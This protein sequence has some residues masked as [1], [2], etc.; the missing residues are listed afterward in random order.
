MN[1]NYKIQT[2][3]L[4]QVYGMGT[5]KPDWMSKNKKIALNAVRKETDPIKLLEIAKNAPQY[6]VRKEAVKELIGQ[7]ILADIAKND[8]DG[9]TRFMAAQELTDSAL[10]QEIYTDIIEKH[11]AEYWCPEVVA[12]LTDQEVLTDIAKYGP[13]EEM[14]EAALQKLIDLWDPNGEQSM[15]ST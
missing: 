7:N 6:L 4:T 3:K 9:Q 11:E 14:R 13:N 15:L 1:K 12:C 10:V 2:H 5:L 8:K